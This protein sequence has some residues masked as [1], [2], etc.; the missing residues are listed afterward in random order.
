MS[1]LMT[2]AAQ[3]F[4]IADEFVPHVFVATVPVVDL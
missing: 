4:E 1:F 2:V 3:R